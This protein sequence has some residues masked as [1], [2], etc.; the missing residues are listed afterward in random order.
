MKKIFLFSLFFISLLGNLSAQRVD[1]EEL[2]KHI[3]G[4]IHFINYT[5]PER[6]VQKREEIINIGKTLAIRLA[7][8]GREGHIALKYSVYHIIGPVKEKGLDADIIS[9][10][11]EARVD[12]IKNVRRIIRGYLT[13]AYG[14]SDL[15][16]STLAVFI[17]LYNA[18]YRG[19]I[20]YFATRY[21]KEVVSYLN[22]EN[23]GISLKYYEWPGKTRLVIPLSPEAKKGEISSIS[24]SEVSTKAVVEA[25]RKTKGKELEARKGLVS[26]KER[27]V[28]QK[29]EK[30]TEIEK[31]TEE[32]EKQKAKLEETIEKKNQRIG[33]EAW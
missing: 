21:K 7:R 24:T 30:I 15:D 12:H 3:K 22:K 6:V 11:R 16:A 19:N 26:I 2:K 32:L 23:A 4:N 33:R 28:E 8:N 17:T 29:R 1:V 10:D 9:I 25:A 13:E 14:Y 31:K 20:A 5:G 18:V 27:E